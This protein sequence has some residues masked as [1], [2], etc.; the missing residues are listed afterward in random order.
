MPGR[1]V[2]L[3]H[4]E[5][6]WNRAP[7]CPACEA[8]RVSSATYFGKV[9]GPGAST[10]V[11]AELMADDLGFC[12]RH[13]QALVNEEAYAQ[14]IARACAGAI[15]QIQPLLQQSVTDDRCQRLF[16]SAGHRCPACSA[17]DA[18]AS[19]YLA[20]LRKRWSETLHPSV[21]VD[22]LC[23]HHFQIFAGR[24]LL[25]PRGQAIQQRLATLLAA[26]R[27]LEQAPREAL[28]HALAL[29]GHASP[30]PELPWQ[31][32]AGATSAPMQA[33]LGDPQACPV[34]EAVGGASLHWLEGLRWAAEDETAE[35]LWLFAPC[36]KRHVSEAARLGR[37]E[38][39]VRI[40]SFALWGMA[41]QSR[42]QLAGIV[43]ELALAEQ[44]KPVWYRPRRRRQEASS[45]ASPQ[46]KRFVLRCRGCEA[47]A[48]ALERASG[49]FLELM[50]HARHRNLLAH[51]H[52]LC[53][54]HLAHILPVASAES[55]RPFLA[56]LHAG[57]MEA[58]NQA[59]SSSTTR[60]HAWREAVRRFRAWPTAH[61]SL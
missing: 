2:L 44:P 23:W 43:R 15:E 7:C 9:F 31:M 17:E 47:E 39:L 13:G 24:L 56:R 6:E 12:S 45:S 14:Q 8:A 46:G 33:I 5:S 36:C 27:D 53:L 54:Q 60:E 29:L 41:E 25:E 51:G 37:S 55:A 58:L 10:S 48:I 52:G 57:H 34:C 20:S 16:F 50:R 40:A 11:I 18:A 32:D 59:L 21:D 61:R 1:P 28:P 42:Q 38:L 4:G 30:V 3:R 35:C 26:S 49:T 22:A 19:K